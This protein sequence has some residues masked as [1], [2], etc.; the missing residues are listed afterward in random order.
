MLGLATAQRNIAAA[1]VVASSI[2]GDTLLYTLVGALVIPSSSSSSP[3]KLGGESPPGNLPPSMPE[4]RRGTDQDLG[5]ELSGSTPLSGAWRGVRLWGE[6]S[7]ASGIP[8]RTRE[9]RSN[10]AA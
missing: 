8:G 1:L 4:Q 6:T 9:A 3:A 7:A 10:Q 2:G 5:T